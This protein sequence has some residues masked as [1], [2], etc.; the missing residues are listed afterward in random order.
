MKAKQSN[1]S[2]CQIAFIGNFF[3]F[4]SNGTTF[5]KTFRA[6]FDSHWFIL[7]SRLKEFSNLI[8]KN[9]GKNFELEFDFSLEATFDFCANDMNEERFEEFCEMFL[10]YLYTGRVL[11]SETTQAQKIYEISLKFLRQLAGF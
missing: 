3:S 4:N 10:K 6:D 1:S 5:V 2:D 8:E 7:K 9:K 11:T